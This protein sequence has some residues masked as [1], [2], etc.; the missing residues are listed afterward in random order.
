M[1]ASVSP[2][3]SSA[4]AAFLR[5]VERRGAV[6]AELQCGDAN[7]GD[8]ALTGAM[9]AFCE[10]APAVTM[11]D[12]PRRFWAILL[13]QPALRQRVP[14]TM[15]LEATDRLGE[16]PTGPRAA[17]LLRLA[18]G[19]SE[20]EAAA[21][22][23]VGVASYRLALRGAL[24]H[25]ADGR[26][27]PQAWQHL[28]DQVHRRIKTLA[29]ERLARLAQAREAILRG[30]PA[31]TSKSAPTTAPARRRGVLALLWLLLLLCALAFAATWWWPVDGA[32]PGATRGVRVEALPPAE[33]PAAT[34]GADAALLAHPDFALLAD[35]ATDAEAAELALWAWM[36]AV[37]A[38]TVPADHPASAEPDVPVPA[39]ALPEGGLPPLESEAGADAH[40]PS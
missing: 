14:V 40:A 18:A 26:A 27:D 15:P 23:G 2:S 6:L 8:A 10:A 17:L 28:R 21:V 30:E 19:L 16:V 7:A 37:D 36:V 24:P 29:P 5:G 13:A 38:G 35:P 25:H 20:T 39:E 9:R 34:L 11:A 33:P 12:W 22:L 1:S 31:P 32:G 4:L 3:T